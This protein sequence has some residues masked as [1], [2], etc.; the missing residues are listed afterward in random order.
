MACTAHAQHTSFRPAE[1]QRDAG[2]HDRAAGDSHWRAT[3][4]PIYHIVLDQSQGS[5]VLF[6]A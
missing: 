2:G 1:G 6:G 4:V 5:V 3:G